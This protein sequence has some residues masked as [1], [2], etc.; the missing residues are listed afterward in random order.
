VIRAP[1]LAA[2]VLALLAS[3]VEAGPRVSWRPAKP[4]V[5][6][7]AILEV[8]GSAD[9]ATVEGSV[10]GRPI[11]FFRD[12]GGHAALV[13]FDMELGAGRKAWRIEV[14]EPDRPARSVSGT[15]Q[16]GAREFPV[17]RLTLPTPMVDLDPE[18][19]RRA[20]AE[21]LTLRSLYRTITPERLWR[22]P[23]VRPVATNEP[24][25]GFGSRRISNGQPRAPHS[26]TDYSAPRGTSVV[27]VNDGRVA[28]VADYFFP[29][30]LVVVDHGLG[31]FTLYFHLD[32]TRVEIGERV[33]R[34]QPLGT[35]GSTG[36]ATGPHLHFGVQVGA[37]RIDPERLLG[38]PVPD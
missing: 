14:R 36:R 30:R 33:T 32:Q 1:F 6:D 23:F 28:L 27:S 7:V 15:V 17:Q 24:G 35:V 20:V 31:L 2:A 10:G 25:T 26:G 18:T 37:A 21:G 16:L 9:G 8:H 3:S 22:G 19:E 12:T 34:G 38:L 5:G 4:L 29:G 13:G 11:T